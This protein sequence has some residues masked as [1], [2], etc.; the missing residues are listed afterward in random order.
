MS[1][2]LWCSTTTAIFIEIYMENAFFVDSLNLCKIFSNLVSHS[3][4]VFSTHNLIISWHFPSTTFL[5]LTAHPTRVDMINRD[6]H[7]S[8]HT[9][10]KAYSK[11][12]LLTLTWYNMQ[13]DAL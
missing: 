11:Q 9:T 8:D 1:F 6:C 7:I 2:V 12:N 5:D 4:S 10:L 3:V 13:F